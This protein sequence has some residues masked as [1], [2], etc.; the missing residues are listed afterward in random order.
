MTSS[1]A[2]DQ[3]VPEAL[4]GHSNKIIFLNSLLVIPL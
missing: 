3:A 2:L 4:T 1:E